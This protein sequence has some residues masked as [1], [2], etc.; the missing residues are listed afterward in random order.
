MP[1][2]LVMQTDFTPPPQIYAFPNFAVRHRTAAVEDPSCFSSYVM[3]LCTY[4]CHLCVTEPHIVHTE[5]RAQVKTT[6]FSSFC[7]FAC[8]LART[9]INSNEK[10]MTGHDWSILL[11]VAYRDTIQIKQKAAIATTMSGILKWLLQSLVN[12]KLV[13]EAIV[14]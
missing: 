1:P 5:V 6:T 8:N 7:P 9:K 2:S 4:N 3:V 13:N 12:H 10:E 11:D 14:N